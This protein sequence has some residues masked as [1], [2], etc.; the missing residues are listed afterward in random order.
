[1]LA[2]ALANRTDA[3]G[4]ADAIALYRPLT[5]SAAPDPTDAGNLA[6]LLL[7]AGAPEEAGATLLQGGAACPPE[8]LDYLAEIGHRIVEATGNRE[9]R[10]QL[11]AAIVE[12]GPR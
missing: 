6:T 1:M 12:R 3:T 5:K 10:E 4:K 7:E 9:F 11:R 2:L 8:R